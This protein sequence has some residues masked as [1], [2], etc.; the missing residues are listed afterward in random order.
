MLRRIITAAV[1]IPVAIV[2][3]LLNNLYLY[4]AVVAA[5]SAIAVYEML[6]AT[7]YLKNKAFTAI[8][9]VFVVSFPFILCVYPFRNRLEIISGLFILALFGIMLF[10]HERVRFEQV[11]LVAFI[12]IAFPISLSC[13]PLSRLNYNKHAIFCIVFMLLVTWVGD[14][15]A[16]FIGTF[17][18]KHKMAPKISPKKSWEGFAGGIICSG[19]AAYLIGWLYESNGPNFLYW[20][21]GL[22]PHAMSGLEPSFIE[23]SF[24]VDKFYLILI[25]LGCSVLG[26]MGDLCASIIKRQCMVKDFGHIMPGHGGVLDRFDSVLLVAPFVY[27]ALMYLEPFKALF[28][29]G[30]F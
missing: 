17:F 8:S 4:C 29:R 24:E 26:V 1:A 15:G 23:A 28:I 5:L 22:F 6:L 25:G 7:E 19:T 14:A 10:M 3:I 30:I 11:S 18:G 9:L 13:I 21:Y 2:I 27:N 12:S 16:Y 20:L